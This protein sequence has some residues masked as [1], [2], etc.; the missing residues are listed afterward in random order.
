MKLAVA[1]V[2]LAGLLSGAWHSE[3]EV[4]DHTL[5]LTSAIC[6]G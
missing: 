6:S 2:I 4:R 3:A 5:R 1:A